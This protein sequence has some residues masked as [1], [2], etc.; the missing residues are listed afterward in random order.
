M[1]TKRYFIKQ[2]LGI[3]TRYMEVSDSDYFE[4]LNYYTETFTTTTNLTRFDDH[5]R[6]SVWIS[7][8]F[9][10]YV[11]EAYNIECTKCSLCKHNETGHGCIQ[12]LHV[13]TLDKECFERRDTDDCI[14][15]L[16]GDGENA[17]G[18]PENDQP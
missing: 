6:S 12:C 4:F 10:E 5:Q 7:K 13:P 3:N 11:I 15:K 2:K 18:L 16:D 9:G 8:D 17:A 14:T 1:A